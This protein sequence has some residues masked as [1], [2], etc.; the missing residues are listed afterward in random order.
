[1]RDNLIDSLFESAKEEL[2]RSEQAVDKAINEAEARKRGCFEAARIYARSRRAEA[3]FDTA[4]KFQTNPHCIEGLSLPPASSKGY[5]DQD[6]LAVH[7]GLLIEAAYGGHTTSPKRFFNVCMKDG[8]ASLDSYMSSED[9]E[10][11]RLTLQVYLPASVIDSKIDIIKYE[12]GSSPLK[13]LLLSRLEPALSRKEADAFFAL[14]QAHIRGD[15]TDRD[16]GKAF[17]ILAISAHLGSVVAGEL[18][19]NIIKKFPELAISSVIEE[20][21]ITIDTAA[22]EP[23]PVATTQLLVL[24]ESERICLAMMRDEPFCTIIAASK[25]TGLEWVRSLPWT[26][27][28]LY[29][30]SFLK[31]NNTVER[32]LRLVESLGYPAIAG[33]LCSAP[34]HVLLESL[35][36]ST[37]QLGFERGRQTV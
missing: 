27:H 35:L 31:E 4:L 13:E 2:H 25:L 28:L 23:T 20:R 32:C 15:G 5:T 37:Y 22:N 18:R 19:K 33:D 24:G 11:M 34:P 16:I 10:M 1:M 21:A 12:M 14:A 9:Q 29:E 17:K 30:G 7:L 8:Y 26:C 36:I 3:V 6:C